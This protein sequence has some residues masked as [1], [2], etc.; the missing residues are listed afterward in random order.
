MNK[1][2]C[3]V[4]G[5]AASASVIIKLRGLSN[6]DSDVIA[7]QDF[8]P[9]ID[10]HSHKTP[11]ILTH[12]FT[13]PHKV[14]LLLELSNAFTSLLFHLVSANVSLLHFCTTDANVSCF[15]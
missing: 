12:R 1:Q 10:Q 13:A 3:L 11:F 9:R 7:A 15:Q 5:V 14:L 8:G 4:L 6:E 2:M